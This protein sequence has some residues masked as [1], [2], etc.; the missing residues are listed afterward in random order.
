MTTTAE[1]F[2]NTS[3]ITFAC[4]EMK[5]K[6]RGVTFGIPSAESIPQEAI[7]HRQANSSK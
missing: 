6:N 2:K 7:S 4:D 5:S 3:S 1:K